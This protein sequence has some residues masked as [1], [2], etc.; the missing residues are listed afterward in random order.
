MPLEGNTGDSFVYGESAFDRFPHAWSDKNHVSAQRESPSF[1]PFTPAD[2]PYGTIA[3]MP[4]PMHSDITREDEMMGSLSN[5]MSYFD[6][7][8]SEYLSSYDQIPT[9]SRNSSMIPP[10]GTPFYFDGAN[11]DISGLPYAMPMSAPAALSF[12]AALPDEPF[13]TATETPGMSSTPRIPADYESPAQAASVLSVSPTGDDCDPQ[14]AA[15]T[16]PDIHDMDDVVFSTAASLSSPSFPSASPPDLIHESDSED[17]GESE[18]E[19]ADDGDGD[20]VPNA[21]YKTRGRPVTRSSNRHTA[22]TKKKAAT[23]SPDSSRSVSAR[24]RTSGRPRVYKLTAPTP[25]PN[26][27]KKS[28]GRRVPT[29]PVVVVQG[30]VQKNVRGYACKVKGC[31]KC[32]ARGEHLKRHVRSIHTNEKR[33][34]FFYYRNHFLSAHHTAMLIPS[35]ST[36]S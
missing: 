2:P 24:A 5:D 23:P 29:S 33:K 17:A 14:I 4:M 22:T 26:L 31:G 32:F 9:L 10:S 27:T 20:F 3:T 35:A 36:T 21:R 12:T 13:V 16:E 11:M 7:T 15:K 28:R 18:A 34:S 1:F 25:V 30:G 6:F 8:P 19:D